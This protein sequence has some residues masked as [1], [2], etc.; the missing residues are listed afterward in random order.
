MLHLFIVSLIWALSFG[1]IKGQLAG[2]DTTALGVVRTGFALL[3]FLPF[4]R[5]GKIRAG[6][7]VRLACIGAVEFGL[8]YVF[9]MA[10]FRFL[11]AYEVA[12]FTI[13]TPLWIAAIESFQLRRI[14]AGLTFAALL[15][16]AGAAVISWQTLTPTH[17]LLAGFLL[18]QGSNVCFAVGQLMYRKIR[19]GALG[20]TSDTSLF[21]WLY[22]GALLITLLASGVTT[23]WSAFRPDLSQWLVLAYLGAIASGLCFFGWNL[24]AIRVSTATLAVFNNIKIPLAVACSLLVFGETANIPRLLIGGALLMVAIFVA[25]HRPRG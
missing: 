2:L 23:N 20:K 22:I 10:A 7:A 15:A 17:N 19:R 14:P 21:A 8:M 5:P 1:L 18:V 4:W 24:G 12:I 13:F 25:Q 9:Y 11:A 3:V 6:D 16:I